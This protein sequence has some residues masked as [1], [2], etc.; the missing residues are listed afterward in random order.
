LPWTNQ[1]S[2]ETCIKLW[3]MWWKKSIDRR[4]NVSRPM[5]N[6]DP[7]CLIWWFIMRMR[8]WIILILQHQ[9]EIMAELRRRRRNHPERP[10]RTSS[11]MAWTCLAQVSVR[12]KQANQTRNTTGFSKLC[13]RSEKVSANRFWVT[14]IPN[15]Q[16]ECL[17]QFFMLKKDFWVRKF[18]SLTEMRTHTKNGDL[19]KKSGLILE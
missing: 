9:G 2:S 14:S 19:C 16:R 5:R 6:I 8:E 3:H 18:R 15:N 7:I 17:F 11:V 12:Q 4:E 13:S 10:A 1:E